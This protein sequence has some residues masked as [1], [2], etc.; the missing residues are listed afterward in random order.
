MVQGGTQHQLIQGFDDAALSSS[1]SSSD[2]VVRDSRERLVSGFDAIGRVR[3]GRW[4]APR[5]EVKELDVIGE[6]FLRLV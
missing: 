4:A 5:P 2:G 3:H 1:R 6:S